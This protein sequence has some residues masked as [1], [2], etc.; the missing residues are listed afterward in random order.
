MEHFENVDKRPEENKPGYY[1]VIPAHVRYEK[2]LSPSAKLLFGEISALC[3]KE[4]YCWASNNYF[5]RLYEVDTSAVSKWI[6]SLAASGFIRLEYAADSR[7]IQYR[8]IFI[9]DVKPAHSPEP[10]PPPEPEPVPPEPQNEGGI[11]IRQYPPENFPQGI[12]IKKGGIEKNRGGIEKNANRILQAN[13]TYTTTP[14]P[15]TPFPE[16]NQKAEGVAV[17]DLKSA[18]KSLHNDFVFS[19]DFYPRA[20][21]FMADNA[22]DSGYPPWLYQHCKRLNPR[23]LTGFYFKVFAESHFAEMYAAGRDKHRISRPEPPEPCPVCAAEHDPS[24]PCPQ[25]GLS[26]AERYNDDAVRRQRLL[27]QMPP[28]RRAEYERK[29]AALDMPSCLVSPEAFEDYLKHMSALDREFG[30]A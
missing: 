19:A 1:A 14:T 18:L 8:K 4:G 12:E 20:V 24:G 11:D 22:L 27:Y 6:K 15:T 3:N 28:G 7:G 13:N 9:A 21:R 30:V 5:A 17:T 25:C 2:S 16:K 10:P 23:S 29:S 26:S